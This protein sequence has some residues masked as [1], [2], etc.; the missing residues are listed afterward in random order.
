[1]C[2]CLLASFYAKSINF[3]TVKMGLA[4]KT[5]FSISDRSAK[6]FGKSGAPMEHNTTAKLKQTF[7]YKL[8][9]FGIND[10]GLISNRFRK[11]VHGKKD[12]TRVTARV[13][14]VFRVL[15]HF[16][17]IYMLSGICFFSFVIYVKLCLNP[18]YLV[19]RFCM[20][21]FANREVCL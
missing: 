9:N 1:M 3:P 7:F 11:I 20:V 16:F 4:Q 10:P 6:F 19:L 13:I 14:V 15:Q 12:V 5:M 21:V 8:G 17:R 2:I 18:Y